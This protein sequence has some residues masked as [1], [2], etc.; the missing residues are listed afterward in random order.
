MTSAD[1]AVG[2]E[3]NSLVVRVITWF[4]AQTFNPLMVRDARS[5]FRGRR[6]IMFQFLYTLVLMIAI[7]IAALIFYQDRASQGLGAT[8]FSEFG[9]WMF[10]GLFETQVVLL[11]LIAVAYSAGSI[12]QEREKQTYEILAV[13]RLA[14]SEVV[15][16]KL[17]S[18]VLLCYLLMFT[19]APLAAFCL[20][21]GGVSPAEVA[22]GYGLL[23]LKIPLWVALGIFA[24]ITC[25]R[26]GNAYIVT[27]VI[28]FVETM[29]SV[30]LM[31]P[32]PNG[33]QP[34]LFS[35]FLAPL[36]SEFD[37]KLFKWGLP[38]WLLPLPYNLL[39]TA[40]TVVASAEAMLHYP[41]KR[42]PLL[43]GLAL[44][45][46]L[47]LAFLVTASIIGI[48]SGL[49]F[50]PPTARSVRPPRFPLPVVPIICS[51]WLYA[52]WFIPVVTS[53]PPAKKAGE[54]GYPRFLASLNPR[55]WFHRD[56]LGGLGFCFLVWLT[57]LLGAFSAGLLS[58]LSN[59]GKLPLAFLISPVLLLALTILALSLVAYCTFGA[60][61]AITHG[62]RREVSLA[63]FLIFLLMNSLA[64]VYVLG[65]DLLRRVPS[66]PALIFASPAAAATAVFGRTVGPKW[67]TFTPDEAFIYGLG[68][69]LLLILLANLY[70]TRH[71]RKASRG[72]TSN[73]FTVSES[74]TLEQSP[75]APE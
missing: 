48:S 23:A 25:G 40:L 30:F 15:L 46:T 73:T 54:P 49:Q 3:R 39:L 32:S 31:Q 53:Y 36:A 65:Y 27:F 22:L 24:S 26:T 1:S 71:R 12:S 21:F 29:V 51:A 63:T 18:V 45:V 42:S 69:S 59:W 11:A 14:S 19:S 10:V 47:L 62:S 57:T 56:A 9:R 64:V 66:H 61:L 41:P 70:Y 67:R 34:G 5:I 33:T 8:P 37:F 50:V 43:R 52:C 72:V 13:T 60:A 75:A 58:S 28:I 2:A 6:F 35:P 74:A 68:Y 16:G 55:V 38:P 20:I 17:W 44:A 7:G 4:R